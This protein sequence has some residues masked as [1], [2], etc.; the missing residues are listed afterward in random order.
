MS[1]YTLKCYTQEQRLSMSQELATFYHYESIMDLTFK[2]Q[3]TVETLML[4]SD[5][6]LASLYN[7]HIICPSKY[8]I[9]NRP[10]PE[11]F[12]RRKIS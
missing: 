4:L 3:H 10:L 9:K 2:P 7:S 8:T 1:K 6:E 11:S 5:L 12:K